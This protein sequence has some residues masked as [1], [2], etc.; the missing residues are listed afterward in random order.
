MKMPTIQTLRA[1]AI[2]HSLFSPTTLRDA[3]ERLKFV[4][5]DPIRSPARA[6]DLI[7]RHR[8]EHY[9]AGDLEREYPT[10]DLEEDVLYAYGF[11]TRDVWQLLHPRKTNDLT[12]FERNILETVAKFGETHPRQ[13]EER[14]GRERVVNAWGGFSKATTRALE[15]LHHCGLLRVARRAEGIRIYEAK[16]TA[17][18]QTSDDTGEPG[19]RL[20]KL[21]LV[22]SNIFAPV[23]ERCLREASA[24]LRRSLPQPFS[25]KTIIAE[26]L[27]S[28]ELEKLTVDGIDY[29]YPFGS[30]TRS[31]IPQGVR[32]LAP[33]DP[34]VWDR[35]RFEH[36]WGW[37]YRF[38]AYTPPAKRLRGYYALPLLW[39]DAIIGWANV[40]V[41]KQ[42]MNFEFGFIDKKPDDSEFSPEL[43]REIN[44]LEIFL[45]LKKLSGA[46]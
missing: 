24:P 16:T 45:D 36:F 12:E 3:A 10:L 34:L 40:R 35:R 41:E 29:L 21:I 30:L 43:E 23:T 38:E 28:G 4:Q 46:E 19:E 31:E 32:L 17:P 44:R 25:I 6:Q 37:M 1:H 7:L 13:L 18:A 22:I 5:A 15:K 11:L 9:R 39:R 33:F 42:V 8:V 20:K 27:K 26:L 2:S 14:F